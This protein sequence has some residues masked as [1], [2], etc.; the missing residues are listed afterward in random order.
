MNVLSL[1]VENSA[2]FGNRVVPLHQVPAAAGA[3]HD[4]YA[5]IQT[6]RFG[7]VMSQNWMAQTLLQDASV[8]K[9]E[10]SVLLPVNRKD[11]DRWFNLL[12]EACRLMAPK[13]ILLADGCQR[14]PVAVTPNADRS[15]EVRIQTGSS[16]SERTLG[17]AF[18]SLGL[19]ESERDV[20]RCLLRGQKP[21]MIASQKFRSES[22]VRSHI[23][24]LLAKCGCNSLQEVIVLFGRMPEVS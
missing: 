1:E 20:L 18:A 11:D 24:S 3:N 4:A 12:L 10:H 13:L 2:R 17:V 9:I 14:T 6:D 22:T 23:K 8:F 16:V 19:T 5:L 15:L 7:H 21:K